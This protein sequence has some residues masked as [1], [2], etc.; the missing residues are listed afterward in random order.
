M[1]WRSSAIKP[2]NPRPV[3][4]VPTVKTEVPSFS[5]VNTIRNRD[6]NAHIL[7]VTVKTTCFWLQPERSKSRLTTALGKTR[8][9]LPSA[10]QSNPR[11]VHPFPR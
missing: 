11:K 5:G 7:P 10:K 8:K 3:K 4:I 2:N 6:T 1:N 9:Q